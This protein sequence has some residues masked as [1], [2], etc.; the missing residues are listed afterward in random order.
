MVRDKDEQRFLC[1][2][3]RRGKVDLCSIIGGME[4][5]FVGISQRFERPGRGS[6]GQQEQKQQ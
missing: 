1:G 3:L 2:E 6:G 4:D 5:G